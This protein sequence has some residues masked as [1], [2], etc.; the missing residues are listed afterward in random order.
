MKSTL[1]VIDNI[2]EWSGKTASLLVI[3]MTV[4]ILYEVVARYIFNSPTIWAFEISLALYGFYVL[5]LGGYILKGRGHINIDI[6]YGR[7][8]PRQRAII[9]LFTWLLFFAWISVIMWQGW[10]AGW[11]SWTAREHYITPF[12]FPIYPVKLCLPL[13]AFLIFLQGLAGY[14]RDI[15]FVITGREA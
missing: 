14:I 1:K 11:F 5:L 6:V 8:S 13:G 10:K 2:S 7:F 9:N 15:T 3:P 4:V 12:A